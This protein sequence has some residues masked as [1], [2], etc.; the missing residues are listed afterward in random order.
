MCATHPATITSSPIG[1]LSWR[2]SLT[3]GNDIAISSQTFTRYR[4]TKKNKKN[5]EIQALHSRVQLIHWCP[6]HALHTNPKDVKFMYCKFA[7]H[8]LTTWQH[9]FSVHS[10]LWHWKQLLGSLS[11]ICL[12]ACHSIW[13]NW[14][15]KLT[16]MCSL[17]VQF[18]WRMTEMCKF[19]VRVCLLFYLSIYLSI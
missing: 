18:T 4:V 19:Q 7:R 6:V 16:P 17:T 3:T 10:L 5:P 8:S 2:W 1:K 11:L 13:S 15:F 14:Y 12:W 9:K